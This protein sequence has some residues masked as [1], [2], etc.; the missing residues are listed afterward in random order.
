A[1]FTATTF[2]DTAAT[3]ITAGAAPYTGTYKPEL[4]IS[5]AAGFGNQSATGQ[6]SLRVADDTSTVAGTL[7]SWTVALCIDPSVTSVCG[8]GYVEQ[9]EQCDDGNAMSGDG[10]SSCQ[11]EFT[12]GTNESLV[13]VRSTDAPQIIPAGIPAGVTSSVSV[14]NPGIVAKAV[15]VVNSLSHT[16]DGDL[17]LSLTSPGGTTLDLSSGNGGTNDDYVSTILSD[18]AATNVTA[19]VAPFRGSYKPEQ[20]LSGLNI[21]PAAGTWTFKAVD[22]LASEAGQLNSWSLA[23][24]VGPLPVCGNGVPEAGEGC[25]DGNT[26]ANDGCTSC[27]VDPGYRCT[28]APSVCTMLSCGDGAVSGTEECDDMN[29]VSGD[30]CTSTCLIEQGYTCTGMPNVCTFTC[31]NGNVT[32]SELC[33]DGNTTNGDGCSSVCLPDITCNAGEV[34]VVIHN[35]T[36]AAIP[37]GADG[38]IASL[39][40]V[41]QT[42]VVRRVVPTLNVTHPNDGHID[43]W[44]IGPYGVE[45]DLAT[46]VGTAANFL[47]TQF[48]DSA[49]TAITAG[50]APYTGVFRPEFTISDA[51]GFGNQS[52]NG[53]WSLR[54]ADDTSTLTGNLKAWSLALCI[55]PAVPNVCGNGYVEP[56]EQ[57]D[58]GNMV[59]GDGCNSCQLE[60]TCGANQT[61]VFLKSTALPQIIPAAVPAGITSTIAVNQ[62]GVVGK[63]AVIVNSISHTYDGDLSLTVTS[64]A[65]TTIDLSSN[66]GS[67]FDNYASTVLADGAITLVTAGSAPFR[68][69][70]KP[71]QALSGLIAQ[72]AT[73]N[74]TFKAVDSSIS[75][76]GHLNSWGLALC[77]GATPVCGN[78]AVDIGEACDDT[79]TTAGDGCSATC[80][81]E[82]GYRCTGSPSTCVPLVCGD[83][84]LSGTEE[85]DD[86]NTTANDGCSATCAVEPGYTC[87][88]TPATCTFTCG[89]GNIT[90]NELCDDGNTMSGDGC[91]AICEPDIT[92]NAGEVPVVIHNRTSATLPDGPE[93]GIA[94]VINVTQAGVVRKV[95]PTLNVTHTNTGHIDSW[96]V[97]PYG[98]Q[99][100]LATDVGTGANFLGTSFDDA[101]AT[102]I[103]AGTAPYTGRFRPEQTISNAAGFANQS[104]NGNWSVRI[105][106]DTSGTTGSLKSWSLALCLDPAVPNVCG[107]GYVEPNEQCDDTN[108]VSGDGCSNCQLEFNCAA[109]QTPVLIKSTTAPQIIPDAIAAGITSVIN[110]PNTGLVGKAIVVIN[111]L[112]H[113][114]DGDVA[115]SLIS[116]GNTT[117][118]L[119]SGNGAANDDYLSTIFADAAGTAVTAGVAPFRGYFRP[120]QALS[121]LIGQ[122]SNGNWTLKVA[123]TSSGLTGLLN[124][125]SLGLCVGA[126]PICGNGTLEI[127]EPCDDMNTASG[128]GCSA[129]CTIEQGY[130]CSGA[131]SSCVLSCGD[132]VLNGTDQCDDNNTTANDGCSSTCAVEAGYTC[133]G[134]PSACLFTCGNGVVTGAEQCDDGNTTAND[135]CNSV[136]QW[137][138]VAEVE[139]NGTTTEANANFTIN[140]TLNIT[141]GLTA[142]DKDI[143]KVVVSAA[144]TVVSFETFDASGRDCIGMVSTRLTLLNSVGMLLKEDTLTSGISNC[145][146]L[147]VLLQPGTYYIQVDNVA[148]TAVPNY[149]LRTLFHVNNMSEMEPND[150][151]AQANADN[152]YVTQIYGSH[153]I[154]TDTDW[155][156]LTVPQ[157]GSLRIETIEGDASETCD[158]NGIDSTLA[159]YNSAGMSLVTDFDTGRG[160]C[161]QIDGTGATPANAAAKNLAAGTY[162]IRVTSNGTTGASNQFNYRLVTIVR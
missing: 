144:D 64:P 129:T 134:A 116:T 107:N 81:V 34:P 3:S 55:D 15:V 9:N 4:T 40:N 126:T 102:A 91:S 113:H 149:F 78:G 10:C 117:L 48:S 71:E 87:T 28:G 138:K 130:I 89:N 97:S 1:N 38:G 118:D 101:A 44:L 160:W 157:G 63:A 18:A 31:G 80:T 75:D 39:I 111:S 106:D 69:Y 146:E 54:I 158:S 8:N 98:I 32:G 36:S 21:Q 42:G 6:W 124:S 11:L 115:I 16:Y 73:G 47:G 5:D 20:A 88:G 74:W 100:E 156:S 17:S 103:T 37:D 19:G 147:A 131:P 143:F 120:E 93:G 151:Q 65:G 142:S 127:G 90:G 49:A 86:N 155:F 70:F 53:N 77:V 82:P 57:C 95:V 153:Q 23:L 140:G 41:T 109:N 85:C 60:F 92:C 52:A 33:D 161:S 112:P 105:A 2:S 110:V 108:M 145:S 58:D 30:G 24:C 150:V 14:T 26:I 83:G 66:N 152:G 139:P 62:S 27:A 84:I 29:T 141:G 99:R 94:S 76:A 148:G 22:A 50:T 12:C 46:D 119:S 162:Y 35:R 43:A 56:N 135:S 61:F 7:N 137:E 96:L 122:V 13:F 133:T 79:N 104:G 121:A 72:P 59:S 125:W 154:L 128:D 123:D 67:S 136:C 68:G 159:L 51:A 45:R 25:D 132:G 114:Y